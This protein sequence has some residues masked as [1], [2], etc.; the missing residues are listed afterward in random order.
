MQNIAGYTSQLTEREDEQWTEVIEPKPNLLNLH[1][2]ELWKYRDLVLMFV[3][4]DFVTYYKQ[5][6]LGP[7]WFFIQPLLTTVTYMIIFGR[8]AK[9]ST[10][11]VPMILFYLSG[12]TIWNYFS[13]TLLKTATV[14]KDNAQ[15]FGKVYFPRLTMPFSIVL[16]N[17]IRFGVQFLLFIIVW[18]FY[19]FTS[20]KVHP[21]FY[22]LLVPVLVF[23]MGI[24]ALGMGMIVSSLTTRY[25]DLIFLLTFGIQL[26]MF[27]TPVIYPLSEVQNTH[28]LIRYIIVGNPV[29]PIVEAFRFAF[30][31]SGSFNWWYLLYSL[32]V[33]LVVLFSGTIVFNRIEKTFADTI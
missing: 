9:L 3:R 27:A 1:L 33:T 14:F 21:N 20:N 32:F 12:I 8:I 11:G 2:T 22:I 7:L 5:T 4:R 30:L 13:E 31:G 25:K 29:T 26:M 15:M 24:L 18:C 28:K 6:I 23:L 17:L 19:Y 10:D 16:S